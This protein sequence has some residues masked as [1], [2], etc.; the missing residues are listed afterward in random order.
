MELEVKTSVA[1]AKVRPY[2]DAAF[3]R[4]WLLKDA[5]PFLK[6][7]AFP[8]DY[9]G[10]E[11]CMQ[12]AA[13]NFMICDVFENVFFEKVVET[14]ALVAR[15]PG[16][17]EMTMFCHLDT[18]PGDC[19]PRI[20][21]D[22]LKARGAIDMRGPAAAMLSAVRDHMFQT[23]EQPPVDLIVTTDEET[24]GNSLRELL[25]SKE[26]RQSPIAMT[27][28]TAGHGDLVVAQKGAFFSKLEVPGRAGHSSRPWL[29]DNPVNRLARIVTELEMAFP[30][31]EDEWPDWQQT[32]VFTQVSASEAANQIGQRAVATVD[33]R[34]PQGMLL[35]EAMDNVNGVL[36]DD[37]I[38]R[39]P[40]VHASPLE[41]DER[42][43]VIELFLDSAELATGERPRIVGE[44]GSSD[45]RLFQDAG[46]P[47][48]LYGARGGCA[49]SD[50]EHVSINSLI[51]LY[52]TTR[53]VLRS[54]ASQRAYPATAT[55]LTPPEG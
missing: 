37:C 16:E 44:H 53:L 47:A 27:P 35:S 8:D 45:A 21:G 3:L 43:P 52:Q 12:W 40:F 46:I 23:G 25:E 19:N 32:V 4:H 54:L 24:G 48:F 50:D 31:V 26:V 38:L 41:A 20:D 14:P 49:H 34:Y 17:P 7:E 29:A 28:D 42:H 11:R 39:D 9:A 2:V 55:R 10:K 33:V 30:I 18:V 6:L 36:P 1:K 13:D 22:V 51:D 5:I 15:C